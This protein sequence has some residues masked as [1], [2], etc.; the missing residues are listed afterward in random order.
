MSFQWKTTYILWCLG[1]TNCPYEMK[2]GNNMQS[3][4]EKD[5]A[6]GNCWGRKGGYNQNFS[7][8]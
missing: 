4:K 5:G 3:E 1:S 8:M 7:K 6:P 2:Q